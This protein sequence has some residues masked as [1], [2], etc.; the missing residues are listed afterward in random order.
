MCP[1]FDPGSF[2]RNMFVEQIHSSNNIK[3]NKLR[4]LSPRV[5]YTDRPSLVGEVSANFLQIEGVVWSAQH[6]PMA[7][8]SVF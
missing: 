1:V 8:F 7:V 4:G 5:N 3:L 6:I 2:E